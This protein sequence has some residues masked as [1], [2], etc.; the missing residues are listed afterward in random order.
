MLLHQMARGC[1]GK[2]HQRLTPQ[3]DSASHTKQ[4][5]AFV[6]SRRNIN[7]LTLTAANGPASARIG[8]QAKRGLLSSIPSTCTSMFV[9]QHFAT[10]LHWFTD[11][12]VQLQ[13]LTINFDKVSWGK[14]P[15]FDPLSAA[16]SLCHLKE[17]QTLK[18]S[19]VSDYSGKDAFANCLAKCPACLQALTVQGI[20]PG[21]LTLVSRSEA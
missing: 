15:S 19:P 2:L 7:Q 13:H 21:L 4:I 20:K 16:P 9:D 18:L 11:L 6:M 1:Q 14:G 3:A 12:A 17:L 10:Q 5:S 8:S